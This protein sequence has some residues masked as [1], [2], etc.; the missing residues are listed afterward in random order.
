[1]TPE[2]KK[3]YDAYLIQHINGVQKAYEW[4]KFYLP[5]AL[6]GASVEMLDENIASHDRSKYSDEEYIPYA[7]YFYGEKTK[8]VEAAFNYAWLHHIH[9]NPHHWQYWVLIHDDEPAENLEMPKEY[10][11]E[12][13]CDWWSFSWK[14]G[15]LD[16][17]FKWYE[18]HKD[19][20]LGKETRK[21]VENILDLMAEKLKDIK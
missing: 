7:D 13:I 1:M 2:M 11:I 19:M 3:Q 16:E 8:E 6:E 17:I 21:T 20:Q 12:M 5:E 14:T 4:L 18:A 15:K 10:I 9:M